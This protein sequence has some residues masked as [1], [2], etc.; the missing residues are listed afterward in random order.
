[1]TTTIKTRLADII[2][3]EYNK[4]PPDR[5]P[6]ED[7][8]AEAIVGTLGLQLTLG[9]QY[10]AFNVVLTDDELDRAGFTHHRKAKA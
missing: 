6:H 1:M 5:H 10:V 4:H 8:L 3:T 7:T 2:R 9:G